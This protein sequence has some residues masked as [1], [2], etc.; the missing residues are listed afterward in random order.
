MSTVGWI[1]LVVANIRLYWLVG[2]VVFKDWGD[3]WE[4]V[5]FWLT[6]DIISL[7]RGEW[8]EDQWAQMKLFVWL[9]LCAGAVLAEGLAL[10]PRLN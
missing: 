2:W 1:I 3:F 10:G 4:C 5:K 8:I 9:A 6:P 7:F